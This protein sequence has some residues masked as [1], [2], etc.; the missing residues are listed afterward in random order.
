MAF[1]NRWLQFLRFLEGL[2]EILDVVTT[3]LG[4]VATVGV[5]L[6][7]LLVFLGTDASTAATL[8]GSVTLGLS[9]LIT[10]PD[11]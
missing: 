10:R 1:L 7:S 9:C 2:L 6:Y 4:T 8:A 3:P 11:F 5:M